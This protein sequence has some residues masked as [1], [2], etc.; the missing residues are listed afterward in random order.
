[1]A[2]FELGFRPFFLLAGLSASFMM[3]LRIIS[4]RWGEA[5][6]NYFDPTSWHS[7]E[8]LFGYGVAV[9]SGFLLAAV[10]NWINQP[11]PKGKPLAALA[12]LWLTGRILPFF[13]QY[14]P[15]WLIAFSDWIFIPVLLAVIGIPIVR[16]KNVRNYGFLLVLGVMS[17]AN[18]EVHLR[19]LGIA[20][21]DL[22]FGIT[23]MLNLIIL[24]I[25]LMGGRVIPF[26][27]RSSIP[28]ATTNIRI[29]VEW[30]AV[31]FS[32]ALMAGEVVQ[33]SPEILG[34]L[35]GSAAILHTLRLVGWHD[36]RVWKTPL[37][38]VLHL[39][40]AWIVVGYA[41]TALA[42]YSL[43][44][45]FLATHAFTTGG[46][47]L[48]TLGMM[49]RVSLGHSGRPL[50][51]PRMT[52]LAFAL[53]NVSALLRVVAPVF[54]ISNYGSWILL[55]GSLWILAFLFFLW[56]YFPML[57]APRIDGRPG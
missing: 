38:W 47:G 32:I 19:Q 16:F 34:I 23:F 42:K 11:M 10:G 46:I 7:H 35:A 25:V 4:F 14:I 57:I 48:V 5:F 9:I 44:L 27:T 12:V 3:F 43:I 33:L 18:A 56:D 2:L 30:G 52:V 54:S 22:P 28:E 6:P 55:S 53:L 29:P 26:F 20:I 50:L 31:G 41:L 45:P 37:L 1:M 15:D 49:A 24:M 13:P 8:M 21:T 40:Y 36:I 51:P 17:L 39:G